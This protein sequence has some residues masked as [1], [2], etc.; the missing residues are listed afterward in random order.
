MNKDIKY[1]LQD[2]TVWWVAL[3]GEHLPLRLQL[4]WSFEQELDLRNQQAV[5]DFMA[6]ES[7]K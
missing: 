5:K 2:T 4:D 1:T 7:R 6:A 3:S